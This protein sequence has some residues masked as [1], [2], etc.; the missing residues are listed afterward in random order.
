MKDIDEYIS[1]HL[2]CKRALAVKMDLKGYGHDVIADLLQKGV[3]K[4]LVQTSG[5][6]DMRLF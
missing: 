5:R 2:E 3:E 1:N 4:S 6:G